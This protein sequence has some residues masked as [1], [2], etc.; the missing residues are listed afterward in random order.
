MSKS[1]NTENFINKAKKVHNNKYD[2]SL[3]EYINAK[4]KIIITCSLHSNFLQ[5]PNKHLV[6]RGCPK[7]AY[8]NKSV[9]RTYTK[10][11]FVEKAN[12]VHNF[13]YDYS[14]VDYKGVNEKVKI[15]CPIHKVFKQNPDVHLQRKG[16]KKCS[17]DK[18]ASERKSTLDEFIKKANNVHLCKYNYSHTNYKN[19]KTKI[20]IICKDHGKFEQTPLNHLSG[21]NC[22]VCADIKRLE[23]KK[24]NF[25]GWSYSNWEKAGLKSKYFDSFKVYILR[26][27][28]DDEE[29]YKIGKTFRM[30]SARYH[31]KKELSYKYEMLKEFIGEAK[32]ISELEQKLKNQNKEYLYLP[33][34][35]F[36]GKSECFYNLEKL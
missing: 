18:L 35:H 28:N 25:I 13:K 1:A 36:E 10:E 30:V 7:C 3:V 16:C 29:F 2:Y 26:C 14:L 8:L 15:I 31:N 17:N 21:Q 27:W 20:S 19:C 6:G 33:K 32:E 12:K 4:E 34:I 22:P 9:L 5:S 11:Q 24:E 23:Y